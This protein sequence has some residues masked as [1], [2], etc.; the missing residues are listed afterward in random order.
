MNRN[1][2]I[3]LFVLH[4]QHEEEGGFVSVLA[5]TACL[6][7]GIGSYSNSIYSIRLLIALSVPLTVLLPTAILD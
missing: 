1:R 5:L 2:D 6:V 3:W 4:F 7:G